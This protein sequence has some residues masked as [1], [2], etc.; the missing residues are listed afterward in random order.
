MIWSHNISSPV[1][2]SAIISIKVNIKKKN[3]KQTQ[4]HTLKTSGVAA[5]ETSHYKIK[6]FWANWKENGL[7][8][9]PR[10]NDCLLNPEIKVPEREID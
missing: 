6:Y 3:K 8:S 5:D 2:G 1:T 7:F 9:A 4:T 10:N